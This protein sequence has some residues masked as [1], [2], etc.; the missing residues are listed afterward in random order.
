MAAPILVSALV[1]TYTLV[2][3]GVYL[4]IRFCSSFSY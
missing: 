3:A 1:C 2:T 4:S